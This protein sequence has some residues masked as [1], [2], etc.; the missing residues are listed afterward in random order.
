MCGYSL[1][2]FIWWRRANMRISQFLSWSG[3]FVHSLRFYMKKLNDQ[4]GCTQVF[5]K[6]ANID[7]QFFFV[8]SGYTLSVRNRK[9]DDAM[10]LFGLV[11]W[12]WLIPSWYSVFGEIKKRQTSR[13]FICVIVAS[14]QFTFSAYL[15]WLFFNR[16]F[17]LTAT[18]L[19]YTCFTSSY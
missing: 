3:L 12:M 10:P 2:V 4:Y 18:S 11:L 7:S 6:D 17:C 14:V 13:S 1:Q 9:V 5:F 15:D 19:Q 8:F 16:A